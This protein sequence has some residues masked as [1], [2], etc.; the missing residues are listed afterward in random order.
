MQKKYEGKKELVIASDFSRREGHSG[1]TFNVGL[2]THLV[3]LLVVIISGPAVICLPGKLRYSSSMQNYLPPG[4]CLAIRGA[5]HEA[6]AGEGLR[7]LTT[8]KI[9]IQPDRGLN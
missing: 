5:E 6:A 2:P 7:S 9:R 3:H 1:E 4:P 8:I